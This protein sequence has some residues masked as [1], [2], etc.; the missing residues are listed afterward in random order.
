MSGRSRPEAFIACLLAAE[1]LLVACLPLS[2][3]PAPSRP[4]LAPPTV[5]L[6]TPTE[7]QP[8]TPEPAS[9]T[10]LP[11]TVPPVTGPAQVAI[12]AL[13]SQL[14]VEPGAI[15]I[16]KQ[17]PVLWPDSCLGIYQ[18]DHV[19]APAIEPGFALRLQA[20]QGI[21]DYHLD[22]SGAH[23][24]GVPAPA[25]PNGGMFISWQDAGGC[26]QADIDHQEVKASKCGEA[27]ESYSFGSP[28]RPG[29]LQHLI[30][31]YAPVYD[32]TAAGVVS[33]AGA[34]GLVPSA[35]ERRM[36]F[37]WAKQTAQEAPGGRGC[38]ACGL[39]FG[40]HR[41]GGIAG[42]CDDLAV[43]RTG[44]VVPT[45]CRPGASRVAESW[46]TSNELE[47]LYAWIDAYKPF[48]LT[49]GDQATADSMQVHLVF[50]GDGQNDAS[51]ADQ[52]LIAA[53]ASQLEARLTAP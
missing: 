32:Q 10:P 34:G 9:A 50:Y 22:M 26:Q 18:P 36:L 25:A 21:Y 47:Q 8:P 43:Y 17:R 15:S 4:T 16:V 51:A 39:A 45:S 24:V 5:V 41:Q 40:W 38:A 31:S 30:S 13:A 3:S 6:Q 20:G 27:P 28:D 23:L 2:P 12:Q 52:Q 44:I 53:F 19:C 33:L 49:E 42:F 7:P 46:M 14:G 11:P 35:P 48:E 29:Q 1:W 37:E